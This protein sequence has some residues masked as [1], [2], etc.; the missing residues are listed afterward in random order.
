[1][2]TPLSSRPALADPPADAVRARWTHVPYV[3]AGAAMVLVALAYLWLQLVTPFDGARVPPGTVGFSVEGIRVA[4][5]I[6][7]DGPLRAGDVVVAVEGRSVA[8]LA[9]ALFDVSA[10]RLELRHGDTVTY[11]VVRDGAAARVSVPLG[12]YPLGTVARLNWGTIAYALTFLLVATFVYARRPGVPATRPFFLAGCA[13]LAAT[14]WSLGLRIG[15]VVGGAG[16]WLYQAGAAVGFMLF[17]TACAHFA[18]LFPTPHPLA[19][20]WWLP[21]VLYGL[22]Y[23]LVAAHVALQ[24]ALT[25]GAAAWIATW[26]RGVD[27]HA[28]AALALT[29]IV[30]VGQYRRQRHALGRQQLRWVLLAA[31]VAGG[32][33][34]TLYLLPP[35]VGLPAVHPNLIGVIVSVFPVTIAIAVLRA[36]LFDIDRLL[37]HALTYGGL[38][39]GVIGVYVA[40]VVGFGRVVSAVGDLWLSL[41]ATAVVAVGFQ[42]VRH[43]WQR[44]VDRHLFG[45]RDEPVRLLGRLGE[46]LEA[47]ADPE[48]VLPTLVES[49]AEALRLP[50]VAVTLEE[51][52]QA[53]LAAEYGRPLPI[54]MTLPLID[55]GTVV[56]Q[57]QVAPRDLGGELSTADRELL[58]TVATQAGS[59][60]RAVR[61][62]RDLRRSRQALVSLREEERR[63]LRRDLHDGLGP[64][65]AAM[66][67][68]VDA[69]RNVLRRAPDEAEA[70]LGQLGNQLHESVADIRRLVHGLRPP[71]LDELG[72]VGALRE[73]ARELEH[74]G[75]R[76]TLE[77]PDALPPLPA[78]VEVAAYRIV[79]EALTNVVRH[80]S[81]ER[82]RVQFT[83]GPRALELEVSDDGRGL[84]PERTH[85]VG[86]ASM[87]ERAAELGGSVEV[88]GAPRGGTS[89]RARLP[90]GE[91]T[92]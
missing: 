19:R 22:P 89:V 54:G 56:G 5:V 43:R 6:A 70:L 17:W 26:H 53:R 73:H 78:A 4:P 15:D 71:A 63:R 55:E 35:L 67:L 1:M 27:V 40:V 42:P 49:V 44:A 84:A 10:L 68:K 88:R 29:L 87:R 14:T 16:F 20:R 45:Q 13:L 57:L 76:V 77:A 81:A 48:R 37:S 64:A 25:D 50:Y 11:A 65:L 92:P 38:T 83:L 75:L 61:L 33:G 74:H 62:T 7:G 46:R 59:A 69:A 60:V 36:N 21:A 58:A 2:T 24:R 39:A 18:L 31:L 90:L 30:V 34:L 12:R 86:F 52:G 66:G 91:E 85:G 80:A 28:A 51:G 72:L 82:C 79:Q 32:A 9:E 47:T 23:L 41:L 8:S 3:G